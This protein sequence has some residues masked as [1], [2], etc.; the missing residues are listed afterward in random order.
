MNNHTQVIIHQLISPSYKPQGII[1]IFNQ[2]A[3]R[4]K[5]ARRENDLPQVT[6]PDPGFESRPTQFKSLCLLLSYRCHCFGCHD[7]RRFPPRSRGN[8]SG[9]GGG[10][11]VA[12]EIRAFSPGRENQ[13]WCENSL[14]TF[15][16]LY[17]AQNTSFF[18]TLPSS[19]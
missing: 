4:K 12:R 9:G 17:L 2:I 11:G 1:K 16:G 15:E 6:Q 5:Q 18:L 13:Q 19:R 3:G 14:Q 8:K 10:G 7:L